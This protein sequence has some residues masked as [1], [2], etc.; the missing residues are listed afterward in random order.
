MYI[1][2]DFEITDEEIEKKI[3]DKTRFVAITHVSNVTRN[4]K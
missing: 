4:Y 2:N 1:N 3:T